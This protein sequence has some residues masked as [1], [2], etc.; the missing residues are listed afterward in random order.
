MGFMVFTGDIN[1]DLTVDASDFLSLDQ[2]I[3]NGDFGYFVGDLNGDG[4]VDASDF[5]VLD[6]NI[7]L[8]LGSAIP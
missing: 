5:L 2:S 3:Q 8:G 1:Q 4:S 7:Q 6:P